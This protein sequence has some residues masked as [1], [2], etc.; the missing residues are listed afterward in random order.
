MLFKSFLKYNLYNNLK[1]IKALEMP[2][3]PT[4]K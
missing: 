4:A 3:I 1:A 2:A